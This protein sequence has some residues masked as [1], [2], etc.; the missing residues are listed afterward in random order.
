M[1][2]EPTNKPFDIF[3]IALYSLDLEQK[4]SWIV[5]RGAT[6]HAIDSRIIFNILELGSGSNSMQIVSCHVLPLKGTRIVNLSTNE[7][8]NISN[9]FYVSNLSSNLMSIG[10]LIAKSFIIRNLELYTI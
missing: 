5:D 8:I 3:N 10:C 1:Y 6:K 7:E 2:I 9:V 4:D